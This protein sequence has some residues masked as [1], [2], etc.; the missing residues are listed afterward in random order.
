MKNN[1]WSTLGLCARARKCTFGA[2][3]CES[4]VKSGKVL[5]ILL[6]EGMS[7]KS[8]KGVY[9]MCAYYKV[10]AYKT[11]PCGELGRSV[12]KNANL[13]VGVCDQNMAKKLIGIIEELSE[14]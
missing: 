1:F 7:E 9:D 2:M 14:V 3:A 13:I 4:G 12:G 8:Q 11:S 6:D 10:P 5:L